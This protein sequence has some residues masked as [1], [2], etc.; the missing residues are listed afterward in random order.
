MFAFLARFF[1][2]FFFAPVVNGH[3]EQQSGT[4]REQRG[5]GILNRGDGKDWAVIGFE[6]TEYQ[7]GDDFQAGDL[8]GTK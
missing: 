3:A 5:D 2:S 7:M 4:S 1:L 6:L 8:S